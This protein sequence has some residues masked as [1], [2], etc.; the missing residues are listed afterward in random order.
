MIPHKST[1]R[2]FYQIIWLS[3]NIRAFKRK[4]VFLSRI[5]SVCQRARWR[6]GLSVPFESLARDYQSTRETDHCQVFHDKRNMKKINSPFS[7]YHK[8]KYR[9][10]ESLVSAQG[11]LVYL[12]CGN[13][14]DCKQRGT[15]EN[16]WISIDQLW[17]EKTEDLRHRQVK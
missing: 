16:T 11:Y 7:L 2:N 15:R 6:T 10:L 5:L 12:L 9:D 8:K 14:R 17:T 4:T 1:A 3:V 13:R